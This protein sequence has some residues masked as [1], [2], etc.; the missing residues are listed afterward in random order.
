[1]IGEQQSINDTQTLTNDAFSE[2]WKIYSAE[3]ITEQEKLFEFQRRW[4][5]ELY[6]FEDEKDLAEHLQSVEYILGAGCG[7]GYKAAWFATLA[8]NSKVIGIDFSSASY[9]AYQRYKDELPN[10]FFAKGDIANTLLP[11]GSIGFT[12]CDSSNHAY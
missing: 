5:L 8:P 7:L 9:T 10:L 6:G 12:V 2:K 4:F 1:M 3:E 11:N